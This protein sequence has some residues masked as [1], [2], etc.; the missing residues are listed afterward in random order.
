MDTVYFGFASIGSNI[1]VLHQTLEG[2]GYLADVPVLHKTSTRVPPSYVRQTVFE[3]MDVLVCEGRR[4]WLVK[5]MSWLLKRF[6][7]SETRPAISRIVHLAECLNVNPWCIGIKTAA[8]D[9][10]KRFQAG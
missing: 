3:G 10:S 7:H 4:S 9:V 6:H 8:G 1:P 2:S 5:K